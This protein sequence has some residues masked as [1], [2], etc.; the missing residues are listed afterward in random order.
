[1]QRE[2]QTKDPHLD[3]KKIVKIAERLIKENEQWLKEMA[4]K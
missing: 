3:T 4:K 1:M 2:V